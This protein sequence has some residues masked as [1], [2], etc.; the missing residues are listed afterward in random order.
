MMSSE[1]AGESV[2]S[3]LRRVGVGGEERGGERTGEETDG[4]LGAGAEQEAGLTHL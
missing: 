3:W 1:S 4:R 2:P